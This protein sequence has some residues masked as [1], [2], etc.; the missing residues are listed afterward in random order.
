MTKKAEGKRRNNALIKD[1]EESR[2]EKEEQCINK[3]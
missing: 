3:R 1:D 2:G